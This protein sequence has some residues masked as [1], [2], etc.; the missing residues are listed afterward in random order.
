VRFDDEE[1]GQSCSDD[2]HKLVESMGMTYFYL[3]VK[4]MSYS[5][6]DIDRFHN[7]L[8]E[9]DKAHRFCRTDTRALHLWALAKTKNAKV[10]D[11]VKL[12]AKNQCDLSAINEMMKK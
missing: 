11:I 3:P 12:C 7:A 4:P 6:E 8:P 5:Q 1:P 2:I 10:E 9:E